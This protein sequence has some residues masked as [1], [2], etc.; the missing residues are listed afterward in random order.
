MYGLK[1]FEGVYTY[2][3]GMTVLFNLNKQDENMTQAAIDTNFFQH[4]VYIKY[5]NS[6]Q[7]AHDYMYGD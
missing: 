3:K 2:V 1:I 7:K 4:I 6:A 5:F